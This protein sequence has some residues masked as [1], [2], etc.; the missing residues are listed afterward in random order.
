MG[1]EVLAIVGLPVLAG[2]AA[3]VE[4]VG[5]AHVVAGLEVL[6]AGPDALDDSGS[7]VPEDEGKGDGDALAAA[8]LVGVADAGR[9]VA[10]KDLARLRL[11]QLDVLEQVG[12]VGL[13]HDVCLDLHEVPPRIGTMPQAHPYARARCPSPIMSERSP[14]APLAPLSP[15]IDPLASRRRCAAAL[16]AFHHRSLCRSAVVPYAV[17]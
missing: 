2:V 17:L 6:G 13:V 4:G 7:L 5:D 15:V 11:V 14:R 12:S 3:V 16:P 10:D 9:D 8:E 1:V